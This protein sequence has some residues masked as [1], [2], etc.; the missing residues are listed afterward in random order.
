[1]NRATPRE[2]AR[3]GVHSPVEAAATSMLSMDLLVAGF[4]IL[5]AVL[6]SFLR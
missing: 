3:V 1:M 6:I 5:G 2:R 4:A